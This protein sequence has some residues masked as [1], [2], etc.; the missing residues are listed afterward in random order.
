MAGSHVAE[1]KAR[2]RIYRLALS[3]RLRELREDT[4]LFQTDV[5]RAIGVAPSSVSR[6]ESGDDLPR[7]AH[8]LALLELL[9]GDE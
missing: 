4:G 8:A 1:A 2:K 9:D 3:G 5:A 6:W 7:G